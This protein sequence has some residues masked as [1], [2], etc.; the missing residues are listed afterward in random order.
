MVP[1]FEELLSSIN[2]I[3]DA[4]P[5]KPYPHLASSFSSPTTKEVIAIK[6]AIRNSSSHEESIKKLLSQLKDV[7]T[8]LQARLNAERNYRSYLRGTVSTMR[9]L[10]PEVLSNIFLYLPEE[11]D[12][13][14][15][16]ALN[17]S[18]P[19]SIS[20]VCRKWRDV[21]LS[22][23]QLWIHPP[24][25]Y[26][27]RQ[28]T[29]GFFE[30]LK[31]ATELSFPH[32]ITLR[33]RETHARD[34]EWFEDILP[35]VHSLDVHVDL[36]MIKGLVQR[37]ENLKRLKSAIITFTSNSSEEPPTLDFLSPVT[38]LTLSCRYPHRRDDPTPYRFLR[39]VDSHLPNLTTFHGA[40]LP[41]TFL[42][43]ILFAAPLLR[44][45]TM[46]NPK[47]TSFN[48][49]TPHL[50]PTSNVC[51]ASLRNL[52]LTCLRTNSLPDDVLKHLQLPGLKKLHVDYPPESFLSF[53]RETRGSLVELSLEEPPA[54]LDN[55]REMYTLCP[56]LKT[57]TLGY[58]IPEN[59][60]ILAVSPQSN[61]CPALRHLTFHD[62]ALANDDDA[63]VFEDFCSSRGLA[64]FSTPNSPTRSFQLDRITF[65]MDD[66]DAVSFFPHCL[67]VDKTS[68]DKLPSPHL[69]SIH[70]DSVRLSLSIAILLT[71]T[72]LLSDILGLFL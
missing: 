71:L 56:A 48:S 6:D 25:I 38:S 63:R 2:R 9:L 15:K 68:Y 62:F 39:S 40:C 45:A 16:F 47:D 65:Y 49:G 20:R 17:R 26:L 37:K 8:T 19:W 13:Y 7:E 5:P 33:L 59:L 4:P 64:P 70:C 11:I 21:C 12:E 31:T 35:H 43:R 55:Q 67:R 23:P 69:W 42:R 28:Y 36:P 53:L 1:L 57:F 18:A 24:T 3:S 58:A 10:P 46:H 54:T 32:G 50:A 66:P 72:Y 29:S 34:I 22:T 41:S 44:E 61:L 60:D 27:N 52:S 30:L 14:S 51:H